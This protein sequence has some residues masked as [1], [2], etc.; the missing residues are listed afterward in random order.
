M[1]TTADA[2]VTSRADN[3]VCTGPSQSL[4][5]SFMSCVLCTWQSL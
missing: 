3:R 5:L 2:T 4:N 1:S